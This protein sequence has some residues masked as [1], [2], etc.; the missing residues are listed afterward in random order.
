MEAL[1]LMCPYC[2]H[3]RNG[4]HQGIYV[5]NELRL[6][7]GIKFLPDKMEGEFGEEGKGGHPNRGG[8]AYGSFSNDES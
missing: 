4:A 7:R 5:D 1:Q 6:R 3:V 8:D 2:F